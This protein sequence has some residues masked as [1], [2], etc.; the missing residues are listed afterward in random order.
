MQHQTR[1]LSRQAR[2]V[3]RIAQDGMPHRQHM[4]PQLM[5]APG[6]RHQA[7]ATFV[8]VLAQ[9]PPVGHRFAAGLVA[10]LLARAVRPIDCE[11][12]VH[13]A[14]LGRELPPNPCDIGLF[15]WRFSNCS[16]RC[17]CACGLRPKTITPDVS[18]SSRCTNSAVGNASCAR[19][20][21]QS[22]RCAPLP[23]TLNRPAGLLS[24]RISWSSCSTSRGSCGG[25]YSLSMRRPLHQHRARCHTPLARQRTLW[26]DIGHAH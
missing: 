10:D 14:G 16:P 13:N 12:Q 20:S 24:T 22:A 8:R 18:R 4:H 15:T 23:G 25:L 9:D 7:N 1:M 19:A 5:A 26:Q 3:K 11:R 17:R 2:G 21:R 6:A